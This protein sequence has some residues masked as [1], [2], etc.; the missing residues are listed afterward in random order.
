MPGRLIHILR[1]MSAPFVDPRYFSRASENWLSGGRERA[2]VRREI[3]EKEEK[4]KL[5]ARKEEWSE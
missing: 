2:R 1:I 5:G 4:K 3:K